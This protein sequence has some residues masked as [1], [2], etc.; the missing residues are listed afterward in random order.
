MKKPN[1]NARALALDIIHQVF[2]EGAYA[3][4]ALDKALFSVPLEE[5]DRGLI[6]ELVY[7][8]VKYRD[9]LDYILNHYTKKPIHQSDP[10]LRDILRMSVYQIDQLD[11]LPDHAVVHEAVN[12]AKNKKRHG[13]KFINGVLRA[14]LREPNKVIW[15]NKKKHFAHWLAK[16]E[17]FPQ[18]II[19]SWIGQYGKV[20][21]EA[22]VKYMNQPAELWIRTNTLKT[23][24]SSLVAYFEKEG[25]RCALGTYAPEAVHLYQMKPLRDDV[26]FQKGEYTVQ[27]QSSMLVGHAAAPTA[28]MR[29]LD[30]CAAPGGKTTHLAALS[31]DDAV[32]IAG[33]IHVHRVALIK[34]NVQRLGIKNI[35]PQV[36]DG[37]NLSDLEDASFDM[38]LLDA[39]CSGLGVLNRRPD[40][41]WHKHRQE[42]TEL[43]Q[44]QTELLEEAAKKLKPGGRLIYSTCTTV[45]SENQGQVRQFLD[46]HPE[47]QREALPELFNDLTENATAMGEVFLLP[48]K[49]RMDGFYIARMK[50]GGVS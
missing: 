35:H 23:D 13:D 14:Y 33:D 42:L 37:R 32:I 20:E 21:A 9:R 8:T 19:E 1:S 36:L 46:R 18:W 34:E 26:A 45:P 15:P 5:R 38:I 41:R 6:T 43:V 10:W 39:P 25:I 24:R 47:I 30:V 7:G 3:N 31:H 29:V 4:L 16:T 11:K 50:K 28:G 44:L 49:H 17:S 27:D 2:E 40:S 12:L 22:M 48:S